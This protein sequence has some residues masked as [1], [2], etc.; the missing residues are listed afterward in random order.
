MNKYM[1]LVSLV[2]LCYFAASC[3]GNA[4]ED[5]SHLSRDDLGFTKVS[6]RGLS[7][8]SG[9][10]TL[11]YIFDEN[12]N[13]VYIITCNRIHCVPTFRGAVN[14]TF[15]INPANSSSFDALVNVSD[16]S[17]QHDK[18]KEL[19]EKINKVQENIYHFNSGLKMNSLGVLMSAVVNRFSKYVTVGFHLHRDYWEM[20][21]S[22]RVSTSAEKIS[23]VKNIYNSL[24]FAAN[25]QSAVMASHSHRIGKI[26]KFTLL[27]SS[28]LIGYYAVRRIKANKTLDNLNATVLKSKGV[29]EDRDENVLFLVKSHLQEG[30]SVEN[31]HKF[32]TLNFPEM[33]IK[34]FSFRT[35]NN[36]RE[37]AGTLRVPLIYCEPVSDKEACETIDHQKY[38]R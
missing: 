36:L 30:Q 10:K 27:V 13:H 3:S 15:I 4:Q 11:K 37:I 29:Y 6:L 24:H 5:V 21:K 17:D 25:N 22:L 8:T 12:R 1:R 35:M 33:D 20:L 38:S 2:F 18:I 23:I 7:I 34:D 28:I 16:V 19:N 26:S 14:D 31:S 32:Y 9:E